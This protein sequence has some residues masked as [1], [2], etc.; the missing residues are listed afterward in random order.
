MAKRRANGKGS[1]RKRPDG[2]WEGRYTAGRDPETGKTVFTDIWQENRKIM[3][4]TM[5]YNARFQRM[6]FSV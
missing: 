1:I 2:R 6:C 4:Y 5:F 3:T